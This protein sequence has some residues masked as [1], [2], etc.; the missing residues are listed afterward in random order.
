MN[1]EGR[2]PFDNTLCYR[3]RAPVF[4]KAFPVLPMAMEG[5]RQRSLLGSQAGLGKSGRVSS[6]EGVH[7]FLFRY[8]YF[9]QKHFQVHLNREEQSQVFA[10]PPPSF[11]SLL[12]L[13]ALCYRQPLTVSLSV[14][15]KRKDDQGRKSSLRNSFI[16][17]P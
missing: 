11:F 13:C 12:V 6:T 5:L 9:L 14:L 4:H 1:S 7:V 15:S 2:I 10:T 17:F 3:T 16:P 8:G